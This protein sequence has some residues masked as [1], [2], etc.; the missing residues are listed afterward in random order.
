MD[1][2][3]QPQ[4]APAPGFVANPPRPAPAGP[5]RQADPP[6]EYAKILDDTITRE[7]RPRFA[8]RGISI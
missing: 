8:A 2:F 6:R 3:D 7:L 4:T 1:P 5:P